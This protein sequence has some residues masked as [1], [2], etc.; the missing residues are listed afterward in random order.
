MEKRTLFGKNLRADEAVESPRIVADF[1]VFG[2]VYDM[3]WGAYEQIDPHAFDNTL[4]G[5]IRALI[6][7]ETSMVLGRTKAGTLRLYVDEYAL[8]GEIDI[9]PD[10]RQAMDLYARV[11]RG[12]VSQCSFGFEIIREER[13][14]I[15]EG[16]MW[17]IR[18]VKLWEVSIV[19]FPAYEATSAV[20]RTSAD[21]SK[22][23]ADWKNRMK[24]RI[25]NAQ[26]FGNTGKA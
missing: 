12:D 16:V 21:G 9:N 1:V 6:D 22:A 15:P 24:E 19:T 2:D 26:T 10:D 18:E 7:H 5:D 11:K 20:A 23:F 8:R 14:E 3:G 25:S 13:E 17:T 4:S